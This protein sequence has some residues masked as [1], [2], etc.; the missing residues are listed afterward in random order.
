MGTESAEEL[1]KGGL[2]ALAAI[3]SGRALR[4]VLHVILSRSLGA[5][6]Y[7][8]F[9][10][11]MAATYLG[12]RIARCGIDQGIV[13]FGGVYSPRGDERSMRKIIFISG[14]A[15]LSFGITI[16]LVISF[17]SELIAKKLGNDPRLPEMLTLCSISIPILCLNNWVG[18]VS[19]SLKKAFMAVTMRELAPNFFRTTS[20]GIIVAF[21]G[22]I[23]SVIWGHIVG[24]TL[25]FMLAVIVLYRVWFEVSRWNIPGS[26]AKSNLEPSLGSLL[27]ISFP[28]FLSGFAYAT[29]LHFDRFMVAY[30]LKDSSIV[31][32]Y[33]AASTIAIQTNLMLV[34]LNT[35]FAPVIAGVYEINDKESLSELYKRVTWWVF[36]STAPL[37]IVLIFNPKLVM[38]IFGHDFIFGV[39][40]LVILVAAQVFN[41]LT[42]PVGIV[43]QMTGRQNLDLITNLVLVIC[44]LLLNIIL[45]PTIGVEG[46]A[47]AT[48]ISVVGVHTC[49]LLLVKKIF[50]MHPFRHNLFVLGSYVAVLLPIAYCLSFDADYLL[51]LSISL[52]AM[53]GG[54]GIVFYMGFD[55]VDRELFREV[56]AKLISN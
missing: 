32:I 10:L 43:L 2:H 34:A 16:A 24:V 19:Q 49:R 54:G 48:L 26:I 25:V 20:I 1:A 47:C 42:G 33:N 5:S 22:A 29:I 15:V 28:M 46:A 23:G 37:V 17:M 6:S 27:K 7:G 21:G 52:V 38:G 9:V 40:L 35:I 56:K 45:I 41:V 11:V 3:L 14:I 4:L 30:F 31:G 53:L 44:N 18:G 39:N 36:V 51:G 13:R 55:E 50:N 8:T 12:E